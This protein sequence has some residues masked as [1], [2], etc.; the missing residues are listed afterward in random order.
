MRLDEKKVLVG[1]ARLLQD[2]ENQ[3]MIF[4]ARTDRY[5]FAGYCCSMDSP[6][7]AA[8]EACGGKAFRVGLWNGFNLATESGAQRAMTFVKTHL[9]RHNHFTP[10]VLALRGPEQDECE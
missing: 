8:V 9:P 7:S 1:K 6:L 4:V 3:D 2:G 5:D 10:S